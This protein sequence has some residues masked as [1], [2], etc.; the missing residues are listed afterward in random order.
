MQT[1]YDT[2]RMLRER[3]QQKSAPEGQKQGYFFGS[4]AEFQN[5]PLIREYFATLLSPTPADPK[6]QAYYA[7]LQKKFLLHVP[8]GVRVAEPIELTFE[9]PTTYLLVII[10]EGA[11]VE[12]IETLTNTKLRHV[13]EIFVA[14]DAQVDFVSL[15]N[16]DLNA[17]VWIQQRSQVGNNAKVS[18]RSVT[19][20]GKKVAHDLRSHVTGEAGTSSIDWI[21]YG[22][23]KEEQ[24]LGARNIFDA[25]NGSGEITVHG[26]AEEHAHTIFN[27]MIEITPRGAGTN[28]YLT[29]TTLMLDPTAKVDAIPALEIKTNDVKA[30]HSATV[31]KVSPEDL[32]YFASR[33]I[34]LSESRRMYIEGFLGA[35]TQ[36]FPK[37]EVRTLVQQEITKKYNSFS[38]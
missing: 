11:N 14:D 26:V 32:F 4:F 22:K 28:T 10:E 2:P 38:P 7:V 9:A 1:E 33:G 16:A 8:K 29:E 5:Q 20:G 17:E 18:W 27:G 34:P 35:L 25:P 24:K 19:L 36:K 13:V 15:Q 3:S 30:S 23:N 31:T 12:I 37:E 6:I 21:F